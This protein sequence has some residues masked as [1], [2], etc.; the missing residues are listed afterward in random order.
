MKSKDLGHLLPFCIFITFLTGIVLGKF[1]PLFWTLLTGSIFFSVLA[2]FF[3]KKQRLFLSDICIMVFFIFLGAVWII[4]SLN[5]DINIFSDRKAEF[6]LKVVS[7][8][9]EGASQN[10]CYANLRKIN[11]IPF[12]KK[13]KI[14]DYTRSLKYLHSYQVQGKISRRKYSG[15]YFY[16]LWIKKDTQVK[17]LP[18]PFWD[19]YAYVTTGYLLRVFKNNLSEQGYRFMA[20]VF[21]GRRELLDDKREIFSNAGV[22]HLLA[23][24]GLH[25]GMVS[26][27]LFFILR[28]FNLSFRASFVISLVFLYFYTFL[29]GAS[30]S[31]LRAV[32]MYSMFIFSFLVKR[33]AKILNSFALA[34][35]IILLWRPLML[36]SIGFQ[37][38]F[39]AVFAIIIGFKTFNIKAVSNKA[40]NYL[41][42]VFFC[43]FFVTLFLTPTVSH[44]FGKIYILS[45][46]YNVILIPFFAFI[47][48]VNFLLIIFSPLVAVAQGLGLGLSLLVSGFLNLVQ[49][50][51]SIKLS[52]ISYTFPTWGLVSYYFILG[53]ILFFFSLKKSKYLF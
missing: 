39:I 5:P 6:Q 24:S 41:K 10:I 29:I 19:K 44:Y 22:S 43:S 28:F 20:S 26:L 52:F 18:L 35:I 49:F 4:P 36:F 14:R 31:V 25:I 17:E 47:L 34:G 2:I 45:I 9:R 46:F 38:S 15:R 51:G 8:P 13:I 12:N 11:N 48:A 27:F 40:L 50:F 30:P 32:I 33:K 37:L 42:Q 23:I 3:Y 53:A 16:N 1:I 7:L 21:I